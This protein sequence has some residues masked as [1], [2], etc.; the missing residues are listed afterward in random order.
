M[1]GV[2][3]GVPMNASKTNKSTVVV[4]LGGNATIK[5]VAMSKV[6]LINSTTS[7]LPPKQSLKLPK[8]TAW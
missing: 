3:Q 1:I 6:S 4:A 7:K 2:F 5:D 8:N